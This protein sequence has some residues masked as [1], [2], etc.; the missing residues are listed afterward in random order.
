MGSLGFFFQKAWEI[1]KK[2][3][4][5]A[6]NKLFLNNGH[7][8]GRLNQALIALIPKSLEA[9]KVKDFRPICLLHS[10]PKI[11]SKLLASRLSK[12]MTK[13]VNVN[14]S[15]FIKGRSIHENFLLV[16]DNPQV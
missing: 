4:I 6:M 11:A 7:R 9:C 3:V 10:A 2:D 13:L 16:S 1:V 12:R 8:F 15:A 14:Q 5:V